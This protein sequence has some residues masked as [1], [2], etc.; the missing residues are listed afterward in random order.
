M[1]P[2]AV[3][4]CNS[5]YSR[6]ELNIRIEAETLIGCI[7]EK[8]ISKL[9]PMIQCGVKVGGIAV[10]AN[11]IPGYLCSRMRCWKDA[12]IHGQGKRILNRAK[13]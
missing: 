3:S 4:R 8:K 13:C 12:D 5:S 9:G 7:F 11:H 1:D 2:G 10:V 6:S